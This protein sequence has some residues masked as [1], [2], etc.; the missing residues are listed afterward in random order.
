MQTQAVLFTANN[1]ASLQPVTIPDPGAGEVIVQAEYTCISPGT[2][3]RLLAGT[4]EE[5][6]R[7]LTTFA[8]VR[9]PI[10]FGD[11]PESRG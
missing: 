7:R 10:K 8:R 9:L 1:R 3:L 2:E 6:A 5:A 11:Y 4:I